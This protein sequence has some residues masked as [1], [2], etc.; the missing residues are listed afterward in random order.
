MRC[1]SNDEADVIFDLV[2][3]PLVVTGGLCLLLRK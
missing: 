1:A 2:L 3:L